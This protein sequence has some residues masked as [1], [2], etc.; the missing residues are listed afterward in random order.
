[1]GESRRVLVV[2]D[3]EMVRESI[4]DIINIMDG[5][6]VAGEASN[7][8]EALRQVEGLNPDLITLDVVMPGMNGITALK[9]LMINHPTPAVMISSLTQ[10]G[11]ESAFESIR[12]GAVDFIPKL[13]KLD[14]IGLEKQRE[15]VI[16]KLRWAAKVDVESI[17]YIPASSSDGLAEASQ[18]TERLVAI[19]AAQGGYASLMK[20]LPRLPHDFPATLVAVLYEHERYVD[21]FVDYINRYCRI[22]VERAVDGAALRAGV[23]YISAGEDYVTLRHVE[24]GVGLHVHPAPFD[25]QRGSF[26]RVLYSATDM[27]GDKVAGLVLSG[28]GDDGAEGLAE[29][30]RVGG[31]ALVQSPSTCLVPEMAETALAYSG[32]GEVVSDPHVADQLINHFM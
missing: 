17:R 1:M 31:L 13:S 30:A 26:N 16:T 29:V 18:R 25:S 20:I 8:A 28:T 21:A 24:G 3:V 2:D 11:A 5:F 22:R 7:G 4:I 12:F 27:L 19:G 9:H 6:E 10:E 32:E 23:C 14:E 15:E